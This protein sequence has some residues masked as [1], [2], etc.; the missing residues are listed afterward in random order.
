MMTGSKPATSTT[1]SSYKSQGTPES[2]DIAMYQGFFMSIAFLS[3]P[4]E[5]HLS[6]GYIKVTITNC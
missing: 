2:P 6:W 3:R 4:I 1:Y 5:S